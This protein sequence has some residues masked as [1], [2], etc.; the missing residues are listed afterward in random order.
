MNIWSQHKTWP[1]ITGLL[2]ATVPAWIELNAFLFISPKRHFFTVLLRCEGFSHHLKVKPGK[3]FTDVKPMVTHCTNIGIYRFDV[4]DFNMLN[5]TPPPSFYVSLILLTINYIKVISLTAKPS[6]KWQLFFI[7][8]YKE[9]FD[10]NQ[11]PNLPS[12]ACCC[13]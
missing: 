13:S 1:I 8:A 6:R 11:S 5:N 3:V 10:V 12:T 2:L 9:P 7:L 4:W